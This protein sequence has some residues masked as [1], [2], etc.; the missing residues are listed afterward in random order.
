MLPQT[1]KLDETYVSS[2]ILAYSLHALYENMTSYTK[3]EVH[4]LS[5]CRQSMNQATV[6][7][8]VYRKFGE[9]WTCDLWDTKAERQTNRRTYRQIDE[10]AEADHNTSQPYWGKVITEA[11]LR[12]A[13][14][15]ARI[16]ISSW[17]SW[18]DRK[19]AAET[20]FL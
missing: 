4:N 1:S 3:P 11:R 19:F 7:G 12:I 20:I 14:F 5:H 13:F 17:Q 2:L 16:V 9:I 8:N 6:A 18:I 10:H 15:S